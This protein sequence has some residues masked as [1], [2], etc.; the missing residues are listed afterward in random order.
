M[1]LLLWYSQFSDK[2]TDVVFNS[3]RKDLI[4]VDI[5]VIKASLLFLL[6]ARPIERYTFI[7][8]DEITYNHEIRDLSS[9]PYCY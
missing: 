2:E 5:V 3:L 4:L 6:L 1:G 8:A 7:C 9:V